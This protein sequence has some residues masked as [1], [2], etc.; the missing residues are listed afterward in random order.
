MPAGKVLMPTFISPKAAR[1]AL[2]FSLALSL[3]CSAF[4]AQAHVTLETQSAPVGSFYKAVLRVPH[5]C[6]GSPTRK[7]R[8][9]VPD[10]LLDA[11]PEPKAG[12][13]LTT[14]TGNYDKAYSLY[15]RPVKSGVREI[16]WTGEL[17]DA[18]YDEFV[19]VGYLAKDLPVGKILAIPVVQECAQGVSRWID[20][21][22]S[23]AGNDES[24][25]PAPGLKLLPAK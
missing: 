20:A 3:A 18:F 4:S 8:V 5:G 23:G 10:G 14:S 9:R 1:A 7:L 24:K 19:F 17:P 12:W 25:T 6:A 16:T 13:T 2:L 22:S 11:K 15:G 21:P